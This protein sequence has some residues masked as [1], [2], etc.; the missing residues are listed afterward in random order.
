MRSVSSVVTAMGE[1]V[2][3]CACVKAMRA[4]VMA[5]VRVRLRGWP[6]LFSV[7]LGFEMLV[8]GLV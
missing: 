5:R 1:E 7:V 4:S 2:C 3:A 6:M 8:M